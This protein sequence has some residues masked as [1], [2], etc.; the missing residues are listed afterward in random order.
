MSNQTGNRI[1]IGASAAAT[2]IG[3]A[4]ILGEIMTDR[5]LAK[6]V[7]F[8]LFLSAP[9]GLCGL[10]LAI[11][12]WQALDRKKGMWLIGASMVYWMVFLMGM[13]K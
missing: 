10:I 13:M 3:L 8:P 12:V 1:L 4:G 5:G 11:R 9:M 6:A 2:F 7:G